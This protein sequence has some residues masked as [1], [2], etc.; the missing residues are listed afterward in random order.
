MSFI[1][2]NPN[3]KSFDDLN[4]YLIDFE[5]RVQEALENPEVDLIN[6]KPLA[7]AL[8]KPT[9][10]DLI[11]ADGTNYNPGSGAGLYLYTTTYDKV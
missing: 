10:G 5:R 4:Q 8:D 6:L 2:G 3:I 9:S 7:V 11:N 1:P